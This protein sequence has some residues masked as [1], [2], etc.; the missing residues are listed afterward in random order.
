D[1]TALALAQ[2]LEAAG[3]AFDRAPAAPDGRCAEAGAATLHL[4]DG[5]TAT[6]RAAETGVADTVLLDLALDYASATRMAVAVADQASTD[7]AGDAIGLLQA[8][9]FAVSRLDDVA[10]LAVMRTVAMLANEAADAVDQRIC[11]AEAAD[12]AMLK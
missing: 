2:R 12:L 10:G 11:S 5:R 9:G 3:I 1:L 4:T 6:R 7:A 8:A